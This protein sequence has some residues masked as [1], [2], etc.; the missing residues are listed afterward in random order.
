MEQSD[1]PI[2]VYK[3]VVLKE[4]LYWY[5]LNPKP[6]PLWVRETKNV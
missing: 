3:L 1:I 5:K 6:F 2:Q 4:A